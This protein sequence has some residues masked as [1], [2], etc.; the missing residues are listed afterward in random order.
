MTRYLLAMAVALAGV[1]VWTV[2]MESPIDERARIQAE[3]L[4][5]LAA[6]PVYPLRDSVRRANQIVRNTA[7]ELRTLNWLETFEAAM[8]EQ[9]PE[10]GFTL[11]ADA[12]P[13]DLNGVPYSELGDVEG[14]R[15]RVAAIRAANPRG[16]TPHFLQAFVS[17]DF[18]QPDLAEALSSSYEDD[19]LLL[20]ESPRGPVCARVQS[21]RRGPRYLLP[22]RG[23]SREADLSVLAGCY[24]VLKYGVPGPSIRSW[25]RAVGHTMGARSLQAR[26]PFSYGGPIE[27]L[28]IMSPAQ[29]RRPAGEAATWAC[30]AGE[31]SL[32]A[33]AWEATSQI[34]PSNALV[35]LQA[36][37]GRRY[38]S[39][40]VG[41]E[42][43]GSALF[44]LESTFG[45]DAFRA[46]WTSDKSVPTAFAEAFGSS[47][48]DWNHDRLVARAGVVLGGPI[49]D[50][51][52]IAFVLLT[53]AFAAWVGSILARARKSS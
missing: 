35:S 25:F 43:D 27:S 39:R 24:W 49:L 51:K 42:A 3:R 15:A 31:R 36:Y 20:W 7:S 44:E 2:S 19:L 23:I 30:L 13:F 6:E 33:P 12:L 9:S 17:T 14:L 18:G 28:A 21:F 52:T 50:R 11:V 47:P 32:C 41:G 29:P 10:D 4:A 46:F 22:S 5:Q 34:D 40:L 48:A 1:V 53:M 37:N 45:P 38:D 8:E 16:D 26:M